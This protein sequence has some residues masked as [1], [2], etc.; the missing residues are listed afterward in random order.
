MYYYTG[1]VFSNS[2]LRGYNVIK[3]YARTWIQQNHFYK[4]YEIPRSACF[5]A[6]Y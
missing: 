5:L 3:N 4:I 1:L 6:K 2:Q